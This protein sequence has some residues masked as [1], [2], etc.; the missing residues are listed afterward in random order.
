MDRPE[1]NIHILVFSNKDEER[2]RYKKIITSINA[3]KNTLSRSLTLS[4]SEYK[5]GWE[6]NLDECFDTADIILLLVSLLF[7]GSPH[8]PKEIELALKKHRQGRIKVIPVLLSPSRWEESDLGELTPLPSN[9]VPMSDWSPLDKAADNISED[10]RLVIMEIFKKRGYVEESG[11]NDDEGNNIPVSST[12]FNLNE[13]ILP[14]YYL[15]LSS[16]GQEAEM[17]RQSRLRMLMR[18]FYG[19]RKVSHLPLNE[20]E[21]YERAQK[22]ISSEY[23]LQD[24]RNDLKYLVSHYNIA[25]MDDM[26][27]IGLSISSFTALIEK[28]FYGATSDGFGIERLIEERLKPS[29]G[30][31]SKSDLTNVKKHLEDIDEYLKKS[32]LQEDDL[33]DLADKWASVFQIWETFTVNLNDYFSTLSRNAQYGQYDFAKYMEYKN[34]VT[35]YVQDFADILMDVSHEINELFS[36]WSQKRVLL[37]HSI[38]QGKYRSN[39]ELKQKQSLEETVELVRSQVAQ[40]ERWFKEQAHG[41]CERAASEIHRIVNRAAL[42]ALYERSHVNNLTALSDLASKL[43][44][45]TDSESAQQILHQT[46]MSLLHEYGLDLDKKTFLITFSHANGMPPFEL[47]SLLDSNRKKQQELLKMEEIK[48]FESFLLRR[49]TEVLHRYIREAKEWVDKIN[50]PLGKMAT[51]HDYYELEWQAKPRPEGTKLGSYLAKQ[52]KLFNKAL[53]KMNEEE[54]DLLRVAFKQEINAIWHNHDESKD[55][56]SFEQCLQTVFDYRQWFQFKVYVTPKG[57]Q[58]T[59]LTNK[60]LGTRSGAERL[61]ALLVPLLAAVTALYNQA[62]IGAPR[63]LALDEAFDR[64]STDNMKQFIEYL[65]KQDFQWIMTGPQLNISGTQVPASIRYLLLHEKGRKTA[66]AIARIWQSRQTN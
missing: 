5:Q 36:N 31:L 30:R 44:R 35:V 24:C 57:G 17:S 1:Y 49:M 62:A 22:K 28:K 40:L 26:S 18:I 13:S 16:K 42:L 7:V 59:L 47:L 19:H 50:E 60:V 61:F 43:M 27:G 32:E 37:I 66:T 21:V 51:V 11:E 25:Y 34:T 65:A 46:H 8:Y 12:A 55:G 39:P 63:L 23:T 41:V 54:R 56:M 53:S 48:L 58:K 45:A 38:A 52:Q 10:L 6:K 9:R 4:Y 15:A 33:R 3:I 20:Q 29:G 64:A 14:F 2:S